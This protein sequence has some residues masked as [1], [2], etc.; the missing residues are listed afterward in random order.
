MPANRNVWIKRLFAFTI[1]YLLW[2]WLIDP[3]RF[4]DWFEQQVSTHSDY[5]LK[6]GHIEHRWYQPG[7]LQIYDAQI[8]GEGPLA[9]ASVKR[10]ELLIGLTDLFGGTLHVKHL[11]IDSPTVSYRQS[12]A[13]PDEQPV[14][15]PKQIALPMHFLLDDVQINNAHVVL[16]TA[17]ETV[18]FLQTDVH[19]HTLSLP[20]GVPLSGNNINT[21][22]EA[23][24]TISTS[25]FTTHLD[26]LH[27]SLNNGT[28][29]LDTLKLNSDELI[30]DAKATVGLSSPQMP[31]T[32]KVMQSSLT[33]TEA[34]K[35]L[36]PPKLQIDGHLN[37]KVDLRFNADDNPLRSLAGTATID[38]TDLEVSGVDLD[39]LFDG[40]IETESTSLLDIG[41]FIIQGPIGLI[42]TQVL[43]LGESG[44]T[45]QGGYTPITD[46]HV[47]V[48]I[49]E[50]MVT[51]KDVAFA[52]H[53]H[54]TSF[55]GKIDTVNHV[56][57]DLHFYLLDNEGCALVQQT[58]S[59]QWDAPEGLAGALASTTVIKPFS[60]LL[61]KAGELLTE[62]TPVY[63]GQV[64]FPIPQSQ[65]D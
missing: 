10:A 30:L 46:L 27:A 63:E 35:S 59:G 38:S 45:V 16:V 19:V 31:S 54:M 17:N 6:T 7:K 40:L 3:M 26:R 39:N 18:E 20:A 52:T 64:Q 32:L 8:T 28:L 57:Q 60:N 51:T 2:E 25:L 56:F 42:A 65:S 58:L 36:L 12:E 55:A 49:A 34:L 11:L 44:L 15:E 9:S 33:F 4:Q 22:M 14:Q 5:Q 50:G 13:E 37:S 1:G 23:T 21:E 47:D 41:G 43:S 24:G 62:C 61:E 53:H 29:E 48:E